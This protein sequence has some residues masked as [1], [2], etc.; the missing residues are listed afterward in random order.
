MRQL[1]RLTLLWLLITESTVIAQEDNKDL[2][3]IAGEFA[4][5]RIQYD[6]YYDG[7]WYG[8]PWATDF[9][10]SDE[11]FL[12]GVARLTNVRVTSKP[13]ILRFDSEEIFD[14]PFLYA[15]EMGRNGG[16]SLSPKETENLREYLLRGGFLLIDDFWGQRQWDAFYADFSRIFPDRQIVELKSNHEIF[17]TFYDIDGPQM[18]PGRGGRQGFGQAGMN[19]ASNHAILDDDGRVMVLINWNSDMGD[20]WEHTYDRWYPTE[21]ANSAYQLGINYLIYSLT[22]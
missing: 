19:V 22:H 1:L 16:L 9:P 14:Y 15:L 20:G 3:D 7:G 11:N 12:R 4:F 5:V 18:I 13:I 2:Y 21:Y 6:S 10:A 8:G 17:H